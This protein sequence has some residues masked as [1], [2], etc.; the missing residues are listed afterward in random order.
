V[1]IKNPGPFFRRKERK[2]L[3]IIISFTTNNQFTLPVSH[4]HILQGVI[5][6][7][8]DLSLASKLHNEGFKFERRKFKLFTFSRLLGKVTFLK[9]EQKFLFHSPFKIIISSPKDEILQSL[10]EYIIQSPEILIDNQ[11][12]FIESVSVEHTPNLAEEINIRML[13]PITVYSTLKTPTGSS[14]TYYYNPS[15][16]EFSE[17]I[18]QNLVKKYRAVYRK[19]PNSEFKIIPLGVNK[20]HEKIISYKGTI[21]KAWMGRYKLCGN[22]ELLRVGYEAGLGSKNSQGFGLFE[23]IENNR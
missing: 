8:L 16:K 7:H 23:L 14:K 17:L 3:R 2:T 4:N 10:A 19:E 5:Y 20:R 22:P 11:K 1:K 9:R 18:G 15:E 13:S 21:I 12:V 6:S